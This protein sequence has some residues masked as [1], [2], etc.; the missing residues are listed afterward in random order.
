MKT[1]Y[2]ISLHGAGG[3]GAF[4]H[5]FCLEAFIIIRM[6]NVTSGSLKAGSDKT[7]RLQGQS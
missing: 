7:R 5:K 3:E 4:L 1:G 2:E 6:H